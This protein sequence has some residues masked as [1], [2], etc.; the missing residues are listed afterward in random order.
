MANNPPRKAVTL[1]MLLFFMA[2]CI[3]LIACIIS[4]WPPSQGFLFRKFKLNYEQQLILLVAIGGALGAFVHVATSFTDYLGSQQFEKSWIP[5]YLMRPFIGATLAL[6]FYFLLRGGLININVD[7]A[8]VAGQYASVQD[9]V[10]YIH[11]DTTTGVP[12]TPVRSSSDSLAGFRRIGA[13]RMPQRPDR[14]P[15]N[16]FGVTAISILAGLFSRQAVDKLREIFENLFLTKEKVERAN[17]LVDKQDKAAAAA[18][19]ENTEEEP[20]G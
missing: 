14:M 20:V 11:V 12:K 10:L 16:P 1:I 13:E 18:V 3:I 7:S 2:L 9:S 5:W 17:P 8:Q 4:D 19:D 15:I 6:S